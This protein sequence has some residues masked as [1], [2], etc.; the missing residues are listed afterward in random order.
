MRFRRIFLLVLDSLGVG[1]AKDAS[2][3]GDNGGNTL[4]HIKEQYDALY[5]CIPELPFSN[6]YAAQKPKTVAPRAVSKPESK[7]VDT[8]DLQVEILE[9]KPIQLKLETLTVAI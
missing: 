7:V 5:N 1:E 2:N 6:V 9:E 4:G 8:N 3:Y